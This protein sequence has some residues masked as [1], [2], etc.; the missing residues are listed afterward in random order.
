MY[1]IIYKSCLTNYMAHYKRLL[2]YMTRADRRV[3]Y[4]ETPLKYGYITCRTSLYGI[5]N[6]AELLNLRPLDIIPRIRTPNSD[7]IQ[8]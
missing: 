5:Y 2:A 7:L 4:C 6:T 8:R 3:L 1:I